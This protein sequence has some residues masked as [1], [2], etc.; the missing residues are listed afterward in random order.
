MIFMTEIVEMVFGKPI[1]VVKQ[2]GNEYD[3]RKK[4]HN[5]KAL[6]TFTKPR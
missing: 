5:I 1:G 6:Y 4:E 3:A 2:L